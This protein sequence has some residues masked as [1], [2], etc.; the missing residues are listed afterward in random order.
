MIEIAKQ[1][2]EIN[3]FNISQEGYMWAS[4]IKSPFYCDNRKILSH[5]QLWKKVIK[6][7][8]EKLDEY[9][10]D[11]IAGV[12]TAGIPHASAIAYEMKRPL[13]YIRSQAKDHGRKNQIEGDT[14]NIKSVVVIEDLFSTGGSALNAVKALESQNIDVRSIGSIFS[15][16]LRKLKDNFKNYEYFSLLKVDDMISVSKLNQ[17]NS[18][19]VD[20]FLREHR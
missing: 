8:C 14:A 1:L 17:E 18:K 12:A 19:V 16:D 5:P 15:Y 7:F 6:S 9:N 10:F 20:D 2:F 11:A 3:A 13:I 4:G